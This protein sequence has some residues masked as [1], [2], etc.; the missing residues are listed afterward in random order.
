L[1]FR[2][3]AVLA[4][5]AFGLGSVLVTAVLVTAVLGS[6]VAGRIAALGTL[7]LGR[8]LLRVVLHLLAGERGLD[9]GLGVLVGLAR[10]PGHLAGRVDA[11]AAALRGFVAQRH[12]RASSVL[13]AASRKKYAMPT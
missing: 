11:T 5:A 2:F 10:D 6:V 8:V 1:R 4:V 3:G 13:V 9:G 7:V 12:R